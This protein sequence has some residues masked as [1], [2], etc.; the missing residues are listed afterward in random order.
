GPA[1]D[2]ERHVAQRLDVVDGGRLAVETDHRRER[3]LVARLR[4]LAF[5]RL[6]ERGLLARFVCAGAAMDVDVAVEPGAE[7]VLAQQSARVRLVYGAFENLLHME[8]FASYIDVGDFRSDGVAADGAPLDEEVR[9]ALH[10]QV[11]LE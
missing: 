3:R 7:D 1:R 10:Q 11:V 2:D 8:E 4:A 9:I 5:E 6:E